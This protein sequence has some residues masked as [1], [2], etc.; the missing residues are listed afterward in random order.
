MPTENPQAYTEMKDGTGLVVFYIPHTD[1]SADV[2]LATDDGTVVSEATFTSVRIDEAHI[3]YMEVTELLRSRAAVKE[4]PINIRDRAEKLLASFRGEK[5]SFE[6]NEPVSASRHPSGEFVANP[7]K[8]IDINVDGVIYKRLPVRTRLI[9]EK[10]SD[11]LLLLEDYVKPYISA[12][13]MLFVSE[14]ALSI[15][16][17]RVVDMGDIKPRLLA[18]VLAKNVG[19]YYG[20][21][22][23]RGFGH[24]TALAMQLFIE[25]AGYPRVIFAA[26]ISALTRSFGVRGLFYRICGKQ[27]KSIDCPMSFLVL[28]YAHS[29]KLAPRDPSGAARRFKENLGCET[30]ILDANYR[31]AFSLGKSSNTISESFIGKL[32]RDNPLGQSDE[33]TPFCI[34]RRADA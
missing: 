17:G 21:S 18:R 8:R 2:R 16:Q 11:L 24:G 4:N 6:E 31:G 5:V 28:K 19:N 3:L 26:F 13:D 27:A 34:V 22:Q 9:T 29:A 12:G 23:F 25:E 32:F 30:V 14:K 7:G 15:T 33:M 1:G 10:D 20:S